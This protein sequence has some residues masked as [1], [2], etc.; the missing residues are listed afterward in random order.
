MAITGDCVT[1]FVEIGNIQDVVMDRVGI[2]SWPKPLLFL[3]VMFAAY[4]PVLF[5]P[6]AYRDDYVVLYDALRHRM[7]PMAEMTMGFGRPVE[8]VF[9]WLAFG[10][11]HGVSDLAYLRAISI[12]GIAALG[13]AFYQTLRSTR[14]PPAATIGAS[15]LIGLM[16]PFQVYAAWAVLVS[17][18][19]S[20][21]MAGIAFRLVDHSQP[22]SRA[23]WRA[24]GA[25]VL[26]IA[27]IMIYQPTAMMFWV[28]AASVW[29]TAPQ[30]P[31]SGRIVRSGV[32]MGVALL[33]DY[34]LVTG[35]QYAYGIVLPRD[36]LVGNIPEKMEWFF[37]HALRDAL[38]LPLIFPET[39]VA[40]AVAAF[41][42]SGLLLY[43]PGR[44]RDRAIRTALATVLVPLSYLPNLLARENSAS[45]RTQSA[46]T[47]LVLLYAV[48]ALVGWL[49][50]VRKSQ[51]LPICATVG[52]VGCAAIAA[53]N[54][55]VEFAL[56]QSLEYHLLAYA[57]RPSE[58][59]DGNPIY[60]ILSQW[61]E[62][63][64]APVTRREYGA[65]SSSEVWEP[66]AMAWL[67]LHAR[68][69]GPATPTPSRILAGLAPAPKGYS[70]IDLR[71]VLHDWTV[72]RR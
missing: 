64:L 72:Q 14:L 19:W 44:W 26:L 54:V 68:N 30:F 49:Q 34:G 5:V 3:P 15:L 61:P 38:N 28:F 24:A 51:L 17:S 35:I 57:I 53:Q 7:K 71:S 22:G 21:L 9:N 2:S 31:E 12:A 46:L 29:L 66:P 58:L 23:W 11:M 36:S 1:A 10:A 37:G 16:P 48:I 56:P 70:V 65:P 32:T 33:A 6:F 25:C 62:D 39:W 20:A 50:T 41:I 13:F 27:S 8:A 59:V 43:F 47:G 67:I 52:V 69:S 4:S 45:Y 55:L 60:F 63:Q 42:V 18:P 40:W